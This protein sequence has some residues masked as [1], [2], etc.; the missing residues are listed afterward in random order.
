[1]RNIGLLELFSLN[2]NELNVT[3]KLI[4]NLLTG[5]VE[6]F[7]LLLCSFEVVI[8]VLQFLIVFFNL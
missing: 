5:L 1:M 4:N 2:L 7:T 6:L 3:F 8:H